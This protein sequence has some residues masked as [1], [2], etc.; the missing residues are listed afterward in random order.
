MVCSLSLPAF[1]T[2]GLH[3][4]NAI[5][6]PHSYTQLTPMAEQASSSSSSSSFS[7]IIEQNSSPSFRK[8]LFSNI[9]GRD[10][11][12]GPRYRK[13]CKIVHSE[14][15]NEALLFAA[16]SND[17]IQLT[18]LLAQG[19]DPYSR[20]SLGQSALFIASAY[21]NLDAI[22][23]LCR[24]RHGLQNI[25]GPC[26]AY[27]Q[28]IAADNGHFNCLCALVEMEMAPLNQLTDDGRTPL[29]MACQSGHADCARYLI[30]QSSKR[31]WQAP[32]FCAGITEVGISAAFLSDKNGVTP[33]HIA[34]HLG[35][36]DVIDVLLPISSADSTISTDTQLQL[37][38]MR[39]CAG[40][41]PLHTAA[42]L[43]LASICQKLIDRGA[44]AS[45]LTNN[46]RN[47]VQL[48]RDVGHYFTALI[49]GGHVWIGGE[50]FF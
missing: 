1:F 37:L 46:G 12:E 13:R 33:L 14:R 20:N 10:T 48:A 25:R 8:R 30:E 23:I 5:T 47:A 4:P 6:F 18:Y 44:D 17:C 27:P 36:C 31:Q 15:F 38:A 24:G 39:D 22:N 9:L 32:R 42:C 11:V 49:C 7:Q 29:Y 35:H 2:T 40:Y 3:H 26:G 41:T 19:A 34:S 45:L 50:S 43:G 28:H 21:G 16:Q